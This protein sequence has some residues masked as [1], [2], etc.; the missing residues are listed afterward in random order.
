VGAPTEACLNINGVALLKAI[1]LISTCLLVV[2]F[3]GWSR[4]I[5]LLCIHPRPRVPVVAFG[6]TGSAWVVHISGA[7]RRG[8]DWGRYRRDVNALHS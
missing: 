4:W 8:R 6:Q 7:E 2:E 3:Q 5:S 1:G